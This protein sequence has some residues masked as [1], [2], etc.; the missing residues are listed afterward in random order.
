R[1][2]VIEM[3]ARIRAL[4]P[5]AVLG[6]D[7]IAG[8]PTEDEEMFCRS[9]DL[10]DEAGLTHL[11]VFPFSAR[12]GTPAARMPK[13][14]GDVVKARAARLRA[15]GAEAM[16]RLL[17]AHV[18]RTE[19]VLIEADGKGHSAHYLPVAVTGCTAEP[20]TI[21]NV[22]ITEADGNNLIGETR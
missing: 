7:I 15:K 18:G 11:H 14:K 17:A 5:D 12:P 3:A 10:V 9:L 21:L 19:S 4:R 16:A 6:A 2:D 20:G 8:F 1:A 22:L 13:V